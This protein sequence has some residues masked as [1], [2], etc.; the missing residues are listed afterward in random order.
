[1]VPP[2]T[3]INEPSASQRS[4]PDEAARD[5]FGDL[6]LFNL[7]RFPIE[8]QHERLVHGAERIG[9]FVQSAGSEPF[10]IGTDGQRTNAAV[11]DLLAA[12][13]GVQ[14][15]GVECAHDFAGRD[16][17]LLEDAHQ[18]AAEQE[19][20]LRV[21]QDAVDVPLVAGKL[22]HE[23]AVGGVPEPNDIVVAARGDE[24]AVRADV[25]RADPT[26]VGFDRADRFGGLCGRRPTR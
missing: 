9:G 12:F 22:A 4:R 6:L 11:V 5:A 3:P 1:M 23:F 16:F 13:V 24:R 2:Q 26:F 8:Q 19:L 7:L 18:V 10:A 17:P 21:K 20:T 25:E 14:R 15:L